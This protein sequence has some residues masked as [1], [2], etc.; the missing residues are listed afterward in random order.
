MQVPQLFCSTR[1]EVLRY[2]AAPGKTAVCGASA[3]MKLRSASKFER[4]FA[5]QRR[6]CSNICA[7]RSLLSAVV[8][9]PDYPERDLKP[10]QHLS[11]QI[12]LESRV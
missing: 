1:R 2:C 12:S 11:I 6:V 7:A 8:F 9:Y 3:I 10:L 4:T 5:C